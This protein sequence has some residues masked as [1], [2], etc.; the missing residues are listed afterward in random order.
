MTDILL[1]ILIVLTSVSMVMMILLYLKRGK[2]KIDTTSIE[3]VFQDKVNAFEKTITEDLYKSM[4]KFNND[5]NEQLLNINKKS[6]DNITEFRLNVNKE[7]VNF[8]E[9]IAKKL[10]DDFKGLNESI[11]SKMNKINQKV[12]D[13]LTNGFKE[14]TQ[15][16]VQIAERVKVIDE[17]QKKIESLSQEMVGLQNILSN[18]QARG[19]FGEYQLNQLL[20][21][22]FGNNKK[23][24]ET[25]Y[26]I[27]KTKNET[28]RADAVIFMPEPNGMIAIDSKFPYSS[29]SK[30]FEK[31]E[32]TEAERSKIISDFG[33]EVKKHIT[34]IG[35]KYIV[36][37]VT[38]DYALMFV[39]SDG[40]LALLHSELINVVEYAR[41]KF[42]TIVSPTTIIPL[43]SSY[44]AV[45]IDYERSQYTKEINKQL[46][47]LNKDFQI[48]ERE[49]GRLNNTIV[50]LK[51]HSENVN[52]RV[53]KITNRFNQIKNVDFLDENEKTKLIETDKDENN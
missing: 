2:N 42:I 18:N 39:P 33:R 27:K 31:N 6:G 34:D 36:P 35:N 46:Q 30:L 12:E 44:R 43:L 3:N 38:A 24:Y 50:T 40:I 49:W 21:S 29:Y 10:S 14:T 25:Q 52:S 48:F 45:V 53:D 1:Y 22:V 9:K 41:N 32:L 23:L 19:S 16:F 17:A 51:K 15:T 20:Y 8:Q 47:S 11:D 28:V 5:L 37:N 26:T 4:M 7:L 13:R